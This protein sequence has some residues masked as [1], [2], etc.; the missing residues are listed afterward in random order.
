MSARSCDTCKKGRHEDG[1]IITSE[2]NP[3]RGCLDR[4][5]KFGTVKEAKAAGEW[6]PLYE[7]ANA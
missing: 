1:R 4:S 2:E 5:D 3:C 7:E 6:L